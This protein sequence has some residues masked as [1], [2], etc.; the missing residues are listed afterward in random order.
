MAATYRAS[1]AGGNTSG[2][3]PTATITPAARDLFVV[4]CAAS[5]N[6]NGAPECTDDNGG[7]YDL[8]GTAPFGLS[9]NMMSVFVRT[10]LLTNT[11]STTVTVTTGTNTAAEV[12]VVAVAGMF[13]TGSQAVRSTGSQSNQGAAG[14]PESVLEIAALTGSMTLGAVA[15]STTPATMTTPTGWTERQDVGQ[16]SPSTGL[17]VVTR[18]SGFTGT[19]ITWGN[20]SS[21][22]FASFVLEL[23]NR[24]ASVP[25]GFE[26]SI[27]AISPVWLKGENGEKFQRMQGREFD[28]L[29]DWGQQATR[30][31]MPG[32]SATATSLGLI[33]NDMQ[34]E[35]GPDETDAHF[36]ERLRSA[37]DTHRTQGNPGTLLRQLA[38]YFSPSTACP[39]RLVNN[40]AVW[41]EYDYGTDV[42]TKTNVGTNWN[43]DGDTSKWWRGWVI[44]DMSAAGYTGWDIGDPGVEVGDGHV[45]GFVPADV[46][47]ALRR[48]VR[49]WKPANVSA[50]IIVTNSS[51]ILRRTD[52]SPA[53][54]DGDWNV[55]ANR[56]A[57]ASYLG[58]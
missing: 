54:P 40:A 41:H 11:T 45:I 17:E 52:T 26:E 22:A 33:A 27:L 7:T 56:A 29:V 51:T 34:I 2:A 12:V 55:P 3:A 47:S 38:A 44:V 39:I 32:V 31:S 46:A 50:M 57:N 10:T 5:G 8:I 15:N 42:V 48:I 18:D 53:N 28:S 43:W 14:T 21:T 49:A 58:V 1:A 30:S 6:A 25:I 24:A 4:Y 36:I 23:D 19:T 20:T 37:V 35:R 16:S 13:R 9:A